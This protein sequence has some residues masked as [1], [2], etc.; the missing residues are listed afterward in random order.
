MAKNYMLMMLQK[1]KQ[2]KMQLNRKVQYTQGKIS[3]NVSLF[4]INVMC[5]YKYE[6]IEINFIVLMTHSL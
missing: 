5:I 2:Q 6:H 4:F 3:V 1:V